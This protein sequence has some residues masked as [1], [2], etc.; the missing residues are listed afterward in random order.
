[1]GAIGADSG[2]L[3]AGHIGTGLGAVP[4]DT[5]YIAKTEVTWGEWRTVR[6]WAIAHDYTDLA[7]AGEGVEDNYP[8]SNVNWYDAVKWCN[9]KS[10]QDGK[11]PVYK[12]GADV[13][14]TGQLEPDIV[15]SANGY[16]LP[17]EAE[18]EFAARGGMQ[19]QSYIFSGSD[20]LNTAGW[21]SGN[22][23]GTVHEVGK[24]LANELGV[25][26]LSGNLWEWCGSR[27]P[28]FEDGQR[29][30]RGGCWNDPPHS[31]Y[32]T[33][34]F[35]GNWPPD[36][37]NND[38]LGFRVATFAEYALG[39]TV[40]PSLSS[41][42]AKI[43]VRADGSGTLTYQWMRD[44]VALAGGTGAH[45]PTQGLQSGTYTVSVS[46]GFVSK[47]STGVPFSASVSSGNHGTNPVN[48]PTFIDL[49]LKFLENF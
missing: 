2:T 47:T 43:G 9:A 45:L 41:D 32:L 7:N 12:N 40:Q 22:S 37:R 36:S 23:G 27:H 20:D 10:E 38:G 17:S 33:A 42:G 35:R 25:F 48:D 6:D 4:V 31:V 13:Y 11:T 16:R 46:N 14:R 28:G 44:G 3:G 8:V 19:T 30:I 29:V 49:F 1:V 5:F 24:K 21:H 15:A 18:W 26:D 34:G 39:I